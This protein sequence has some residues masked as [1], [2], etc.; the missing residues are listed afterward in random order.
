MARKKGVEVLELLPEDIP[1]GSSGL[2]VP[3]IYADHIRGAMNS[4]GVVKLN[5]VENRLN[6]QDQTVSAMS[7]AVI[8]IPQAQ[9]RPWAKFLTELA[10][11]FDAAIGDTEQT[12]APSRG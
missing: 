5:L 1:F 3:A 9:V 4:Q 12:D 6:M 2:D 7:V 8:L 10:D 11:R